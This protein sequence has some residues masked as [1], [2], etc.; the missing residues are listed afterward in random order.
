[1]EIAFRN[2]TLQ[3]Q[4]GSLTISSSDFDMLSRVSAV[5][6]GV[7]LLKEMNMS[8]DSILDGSN[9]RQRNSQI[10]L[11]DILN[12]FTIEK[13]LLNFPLFSKGKIDNLAIY[14]ED[15]RAL[16]WE[17]IH[18]SSSENGTKINRPDIPF[19]RIENKVF[20]QQLGFE[21][22]V[23][24]FKLPVGVYSVGATINKNISDIKS[25]RIKD[26]QNVWQSLDISG[27]YGGLIV[28]KQNYVFLNEVYSELELVMKN[29]L[30]GADYYLDLSVRGYARKK[31][32]DFISIK[33][34]KGLPVNGLFLNLFQAGASYTEGSLYIGDLIYDLQLPAG[35]IGATTLSRL[36]K[37]SSSSLFT[38]IGRCP[39][40]VGTNDLPVLSSNIEDLGNS[41]LLEAIPSWDFSLDKETWYPNSEFESFEYP[42]I[43]L[44]SDTPRYM[45]FR[46]SGYYENIYISYKTKSNINCAWP[47]SEDGIIYYDGN[48]LLINNSDNKPVS[49]ELNVL[50]SSESEN[51]FQR[52]FPIGFVGID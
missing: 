19:S 6:N 9:Y 47:L 3:N 30:I 1:M 45:Y 15:S 16:E 14:T 23:V 21:Y 24:R 5:Q 18:I 33:W 35:G 52:D 11:E 37:E 12:K 8:L 43:S 17:H 40:P 42:G 2:E 22:S 10:H 39:Y 13:S 48:A 25:I 50:L 4:I 49:F 27:G 34:E 36:V 7:K 31:Q 29:T 20:A 44:Y 38:T 32:K 46:V 51:N 28:E 41:E 26:G